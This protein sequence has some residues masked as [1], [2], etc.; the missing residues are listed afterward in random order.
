MHSYYG[1][2]H[3]I[4]EKKLNTMTISSAKFMV[5]GKSIKKPSID[6]ITVSFDIDEIIETHLICDKIKT[7]A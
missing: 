6:H 2:P 3:Q 7:N 1:T 5:N 4:I